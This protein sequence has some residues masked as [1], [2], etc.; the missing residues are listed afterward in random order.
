MCVA[1]CVCLSVHMCAYVG[2]PAPFLHLVSFPTETQLMM[3]QKRRAEQGDLPSVCQAHGE[4]SEKL[5]E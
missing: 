2:A 1:L 3:F 5:G 4:R